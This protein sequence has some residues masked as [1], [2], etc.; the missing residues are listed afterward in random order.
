[1]GHGQTLGVMTSPKRKRGKA[2][3]IGVLEAGR[4][5][6][7]IEVQEAEAEAPRRVG[8]DG[9]RCVLEA[10]GC[11]SPPPGPPMP[12]PCSNAAPVSSSLDEVRG[13]HGADANA[14]ARRR[15]RHRR[16]VTFSGIST[17]TGPANIATVG[18]TARIVPMST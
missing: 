15:H 11:S 5:H 2:K 6:R 18:R 13:H 1:M 7:G 14:A 3:G 17:F 9:F 16:G 4:A 12:P 10:G 8:L